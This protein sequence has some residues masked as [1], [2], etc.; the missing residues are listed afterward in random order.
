MTAVGVVLLVVGAILALSEAHNP[1]H[2]IAGSGGV[3]LM[4][5]GVVLALAGVGAGLALGVGA[6]VVLAAA[7]GG[8]VALTVNRSASVRHR[9]VRG[10]AEGLIGQLG[11][12]RN[13]QEAE[14]RVL[15][16]GAVWQA[17]RSPDD[18]EPDS[19]LEI[20][21]RVVVERLS[22]LTLWVRGA[23]AWELI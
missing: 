12:V 6:G 20:G 10:G 4:A 14:G 22:G 1:T 17:R 15:V 23:E 5:V 13:W 8:A 7:G 2:G 18:E 21:D 3:M 11:V 16:Q 19:T 9:R